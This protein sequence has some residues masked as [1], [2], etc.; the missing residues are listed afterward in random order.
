MFFDSFIVKDGKMDFL[1]LEFINSQWYN[2]HKP[3]YEPLKDEAWLRAFCDKWDLPD[4]L[5]SP[6]AFAVLSEARSVLHAAL[7]EI[8]E[9]KELSEEKLLS[10][11][12]YLSSVG[13]RN[14]LEAGA[15]RFKLHLVPD[16]RGI[17]WV[18]FKMA[19]SFAELI[20]EHALERL[21]I[22]DNP[23]CDWFF[24]DESK[25]KTRKW[26]ENTCASLIKVRRF[27]ANMK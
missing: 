4:I 25:S 20:S 19:L 13:V 2:S 16:S 15:D 17:D 5:R 18:A 9:K 27:R 23:E 24:Y 22:C 11:N 6:K 7:T 8:V 26:C 3:F 21:K 14:K 10:L 12:A 1:C